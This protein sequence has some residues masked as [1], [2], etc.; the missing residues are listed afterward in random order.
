MIIDL[1]SNILNYK[2]KIIK[3]FDLISL[4]SKQNLDFKKHTINLIE[5][6][7]I[8]LSLFDLKNVLYL[9]K[10]S[11]WG[12]VKNGTELCN[13]ISTMKA[14]KSYPKLLKVNSDNGKKILY[15]GKST[16]N[17]KTRLRQHLAGYSPSTYS[18]QLSS[19]TNTFVP[20]KI[21]LYYAHIDFP[22]LK[23]MTLAENH[24][25]LEQLET[26]L[27]LEYQPLLGRSGH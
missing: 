27:H 17:Y 8:D 7:N 22:E 24:D 13:A 12:E 16:G 23:N 2:N 18:L 26:S 15:L 6:N 5:P 11:D 20:M 3:Q 9:F 14:D 19:W 21:D 1:K 25:L 4:L 10:V